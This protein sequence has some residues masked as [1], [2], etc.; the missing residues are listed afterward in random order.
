VAWVIDLD[1]VVWLGAEPIAGA[2]RA[3][4][5]LRAAGEDVLFV[6]NNSFATVAEQ[7]AKL[8]SFGIPAAGDVVTSAVV[9]A[10]LVERGERVF[11]LGGPGIDEAVRAR[12]AIVAGLDGPVDV[13]LVGLDRSLT[14]DRLDRAA[15]AVRAGARFLATNTDATYPTADGLLPGG[16]AVVAAVEVAAGRRP[17][18][19]G[20][21][22]QPAADFVRGRLGPT[23]IMV[24]DRP[25]T[26][27]VFAGVLGYR[28]GLVLTGVTTRSELPVDPAPQV[29]APDLEALVDAE[30]G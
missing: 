15:R 27:G 4:A 18:V 26:D 30:L 12:G 11:V 8:A 19:A 6:T 16:G 24:G 23:G 1:G 14:Y 13:V 10:G 28:F 25:G 5:R 17:V 22:C 2:D 20:K 29:V 3:V 21:P 9:G 7:E